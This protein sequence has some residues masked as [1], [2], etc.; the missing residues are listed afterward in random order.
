VL[1]DKD[2]Q[3]RWKPATLADV[4]DAMVEAYFE[5]MGAAELVLPTR[6]EMQAARV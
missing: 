5:P 4:S 2:G 1:V 3:P 6:A